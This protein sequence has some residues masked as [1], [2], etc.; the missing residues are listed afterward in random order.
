MKYGEES[1]ILDASDIYM[2]NA[3]VNLSTSNEDTD[4][5]V[6]DQDDIN[7]GLEDSE[8]NTWIKSLPLSVLIVCVVFATILIL[9]LFKKR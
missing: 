2:I 6:P 4:I 8:F 3:S 1:E 5:N 9:L 7:D